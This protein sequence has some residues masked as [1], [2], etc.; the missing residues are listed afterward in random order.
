MDFLRVCLKRSNW[1]T[2]KT[3]QQKYYKYTYPEWTK[4]NHYMSNRHAWHLEDMPAA[5]VKGTVQ[6]SLDALAEQQVH[7]VHHHGRGG[8][9]MCTL[10]SDLCCA[11]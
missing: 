3:T 2:E 1:I 6:K 5:L 8:D 4:I 7:F 9:R 11:V 10:F